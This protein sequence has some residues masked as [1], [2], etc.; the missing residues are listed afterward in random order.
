MRRKRP[1]DQSLTSQ[2]LTP[3][4]V[5]LDDIQDVFRLLDNVSASVTMET[6]LYECISS[7]DELIEAHGNKRIKHLTLLAKREDQPLAAV[8][9]SPDSAS[10]WVSS[11]TPEMIGLRLQLSHVLWRRTRDF[12]VITAGYMYSFLSLLG[13]AV[14]I[15]DSGIGLPG[16][17]PGLLFLA[18]G[19]VT[20]A[21]WRFQLRRYYTIID[22][23]RKSQAPSFFTRNRD[24]LIVATVA[25][26]LGTVAGSLVFWLLTS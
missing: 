26:V 2:I 24:A 7:I 20:F 4:R 11:S 1:S 15:A 5:Y 22:I 17:F 9:L 12:A 8:T 23:V 16:A 25:G 19:I 6:E 10:V 21:A 3:T 13:G 14:L 18:L